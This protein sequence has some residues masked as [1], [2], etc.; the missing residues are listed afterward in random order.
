MG[1][2]QTFAATALAG[3]LALSLHVKPASAGLVA[4]QLSGSLSLVEGEELFTFEYSTPDPDPTNWIGIYHA[5]GGGP[6]NEVYVQPSLVWQYTPAAEGTAHISVSALEPGDYKA[7]FLAKDSYKWLAEPIIVTIPQDASPISFIVDEI[8]LQNARR[9][10][11]F[12]A[13]ISGL[14]SGGAGSTI[15]FTK[16]EASEDWVEISAQGAISGTPGPSSRRTQVVIE[17]AAS[18]GSSARINVT[19][20]VRRAGVQLVSDLS[21]LS[22]NLWH[23]GTQV[24]DYHKKQVCFLVEHNV[25]IA[26]LQESTGD[27]ATRLAKA[28]GWYVWQGGDVGVISRYPITQVYSEVSGAG[29]VKIALDG[30][31][32]EL[33]VWDAHLGYDPYGPYDFC[34]DNMTLEQVLAREAISNRTPQISGIMASMKGQLANTDE[35]PVLLMGDFNAPSHLDWTEAA[36]DL[37]CGKFDVPWPTSIQPTEAGMIDSFRV[38]Q[39]DPVAVPG[40]TWSPIFL[41]NNGRPEPLDRID[42]IYYK[43]NLTVESSNILVEGNPTPEPNHQDNEWTSDHAAVLTVFGLPSNGLSPCVPRR[44]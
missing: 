13:A 23:G 32:S 6:D 24:N 36:K 15:E 20:P 22:F 16:V 37:H 5:S 9:G 25:D 4:R 39:P 14:I 28:L 17:A 2:Q 33:I 30:D 29:S 8:T 10:D 42:F 11:S 18:D 19:I 3:V 44:R 12:Q 31:E 43:G 7:F 26:G 27:H 21:V 34:F 35:V 40:I 1:L 38:A 41:T